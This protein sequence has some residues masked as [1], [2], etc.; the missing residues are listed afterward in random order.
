MLD[1]RGSTSRTPATAVGTAG[2]GE[3][4]QCSSTDG[5]AARQARAQQ[6]DCWR[7][8]HRRAALMMNEWVQSNIDTIGQTDKIY[9][10]KVNKLCVPY[11]TV[12]KR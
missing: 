2:F 9:V 4:Y 10:H 12:C 1:F 3:I 11:M 8:R 7:R 6:C 5:A